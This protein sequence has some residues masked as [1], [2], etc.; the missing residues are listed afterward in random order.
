MKRFFVMWAII[1]VAAVGLLSGCGSKSE[2]SKE[3]DT[4]YGAYETPEGEE[5]ETADADNAAASP[6]TS[7]K[8]IIA[9]GQALID[10]SDCKTCHKVDDKIIG[11]SYAEVAGKYENNQE[12]IDKL[13]DKIMKGGSGVWGEIAMTPHPNTTKEEAQ[14]MVQY[15]LSIGESQKQ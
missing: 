1:G 10:G 2:Q 6:G 14:K 13:A 11:P 15:I 9:E 8:E 7:S 4:G 3:D 12:T 5:E